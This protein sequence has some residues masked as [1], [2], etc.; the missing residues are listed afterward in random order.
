MAQSI[1]K[2][3]SAWTWRQELKQRLRKNVVTYWFISY[4]LLGLLLYITQDNL[5]REEGTAQNE[6]GPPVLP[7]NQEN[8]LQTYL[9]A[10][11]WRCFLNWGSFFQDSSCLCQVDKKQTTRR[12]WANVNYEKT[13]C[14][15]VGKSWCTGRGRGTPLGHVMAPDSS[16][17]FFYK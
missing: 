15:H 12:R 9:Q 16:L 11:W 2:E 1:V 17:I 13:E 7:I 14:F 4:G 8:T 10:I 6:L 3:L 5:P